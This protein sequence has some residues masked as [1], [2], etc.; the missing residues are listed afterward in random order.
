[1]GLEE[2]IMID[3]KSAMLAKDVLRLSVCRA[4]KSEL[5]LIKT[6][7]NSQTLSEDKEIE[8]LQKL[9]KQRQESEAIY[10]EQSRPDLAKHESE[11]SNII[12]EYLPKPYTKEE[13]SQLIDS[14]IIELGVS[15]KKEMG[16]LISATI[17]RAKGRA[18]GRSISEIVKS[19]F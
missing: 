5:L 6:K 3:I 16:K 12:S 19:K 8:I 18:N 2:K 4:I 17:Q 14:L 15:S 1:M 13:L 9:L 10:I 7:K 11:Q